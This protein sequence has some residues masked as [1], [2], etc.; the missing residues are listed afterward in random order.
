[1]DSLHLL[2]LQIYC[3]HAKA[4]TDN[5]GMQSLAIPV[6]LGIPLMGGLCSEAPPSVWQRLSQEGHCSPKLL[7]L[8]PPP[9]LFPFPSVRPALWSEG[10]PYLLLYPLSLIFQCY[11][12]KFL[13]H[14]ILSWHLLCRGLQLMHPLSIMGNCHTSEIRG[15]EVPLSDYIA[16]P[17][18][19][20]VQSL[21]TRSALVF[22]SLSIW[23]LSFCV[24]QWEHWGRGTMVYCT[25][26]HIAGLLASLAPAH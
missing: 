7:L 12:N 20:H 26:P 3:I 19:L 22:I 17:T 18:G 16:N 4:M 6:F 23:S 1:M 15:S 5:A 11:P 8:S 2:Y 10:S 21:P 14:Q 9:C 24:Y 25:L 13:A